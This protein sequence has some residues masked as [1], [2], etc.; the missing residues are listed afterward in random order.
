MFNQ[1]LTDIY[2]DSFTCRLYAGNPAAPVFLLGS[3]TRENDATAV[4]DIDGDFSLFIYCAE[5]WDAA[6]SPWEADAGGRHFAGCGAETLSF[7]TQTALPYLKE[8]LPGTDIFLPIGYSLA[9]LFSLWAA[10]ESDAFAG[11]AS[12]SGS[13]WYPG[14]DN[15]AAGRQMKTAGS[16]IYLSLGGKEKNSPDP[17]MASIEDKTKLQAKRLQLDKHVP[18]STLEMNAGGHFANPSG[19]LAKAVKWLLKQPPRTLVTAP[20]GS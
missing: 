3:G 17:V 2:L 10:Y 9:G 18:V 1:I 6:F 8:K 5:S 19:R 12:V 15:Y 20:A 13:L 4:T 16:R 11:A 7:L 14:W